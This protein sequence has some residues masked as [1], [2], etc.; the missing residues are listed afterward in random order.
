MNIVVDGV[1]Q[2]FLYLPLVFSIDICA[3]VVVSDHVHVVLS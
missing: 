1:G 3:Y 2:R